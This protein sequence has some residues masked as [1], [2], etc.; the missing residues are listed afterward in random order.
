VVRQQQQQ[1]L[2]TMMMMIIIII[3]VDNI[4]FVF[5]ILSLTTLTV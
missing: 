3:I 5:S 4:S 1:Q 2:P